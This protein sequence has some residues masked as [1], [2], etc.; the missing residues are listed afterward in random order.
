VVLFRTLHNNGG[1]F[2]LFASRL[3]VIAWWEGRCES[4]VLLGGEGGA[5]RG[6]V[7]GWGS[8]G[9]NNTMRM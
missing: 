2:F 7:A 4:L 6:Y 9:T 5:G 3:G 1:S 8:G